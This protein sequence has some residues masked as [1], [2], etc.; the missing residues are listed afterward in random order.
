MRALPRSAPVPPDADPIA[1][2]APSAR[3]SGEAG[4]GTLLVL[5]AALAWALLGL[6]SRALLDRGL[7]PL[8]IAFWRATLGGLAF[9]AH[10]AVAARRARSR[11]AQAPTLGFRDGLALVG[12]GLVGVTVFY[13]SLVF[14]IDLGGVALAFILLYTAP[15]FVALLAP[16]VLGERLTRRS[17][18]L[19]ALATLGVAL[20]AWGG[21]GDG[22]GGIRVG[23]ASIA[24][25]LVAGASYASYYLFGKRALRRFAPATIYAVALPVGALGLAPLAATLGGFAP[26]DAASWALLGGMAAVSTYLAYLLYFEGL[27]RVAASRAVVVATTEPVVASLLAAWVFGERLG[28]WGVVGGAVVLAAA[29]AA[30]LPAVRRRRGRPG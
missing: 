22:Q 14:A 6:F 17:A 9:V 3:R 27:R 26:K 15:I 1:R 30:S 20:V 10:A 29:V 12:F 25:G 13:A 21:E 4:V 5:G 23:V 24:W 28:A 18:G 8:E 16:V 2:I 19:V 11:P 7:E